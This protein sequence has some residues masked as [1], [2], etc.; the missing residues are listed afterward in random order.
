MSS[1]YRIIPLGGGGGITPTGTLDIRSEGVFDVTD[2]ASVDV[3]I[4]DDT[5]TKSIT[6]NGT[7]NAEDDHV[8]GYSQVTVAV[9]AVLQNKTVTPTTSQQTVE[10]DSGQGYDGLGTVTINGVTSAIDANIIAS[11][12]R[13]G[14]TILGVTGTYTGGAMIDPQDFLHF[15][16]P[17]DYD[18]SISVSLSSK[19]NINLYYSKDYTLPLDTW[20]VF[21][22]STSINLSSGES[23]YIY[24]NNPLGLF[25]TYFNTPSGMC[26]CHGNIMSL[27]SIEDKPVAP[28]NAF[29]QLFSNTSITTP[30]DLPATIVGNS[31][32]SYMFNNCFQLTQ[33][34][35]L[36]A[37]TL[38]DSCYSGMFYGCTSLTQAPVLPATTLAEACYDSMFAGCSSLVQAPVLPA[39]TLAIQCYG[40]M[41]N[42]CLSLV[43]APALPATTLADGCYSGMFYNCYRMTQAP[44]LPATTLAAYCYGQMFENCSALNTPPVLPATTLAGGCYNRMFQLCTSLTQAPALP[45]TTL[46]DGCYEQM[47]SGC[48]SLNEISISFSD[49]QNQKWYDQDN[50]YYPFSYSWTEN[51]S[52][53]GTFK[54]LGNANIPTNDPSSD[55]YSGI[56]ENWTVQTVDY[57]YIQ[58][59]DTQDLTF[60]L[61]TPNYDYSSNDLAWSKDMSTWTQFTKG[62]SQTQTVPL[63]QGEKLYLRSSTGFARYYQSIYS[64]ITLSC[65]G[66]FSA[67]GD[68]RTLINYTD[69]SSVTSLPAGAFYR[70]FY[71]TGNLTEIDCTLN[72]VT[73]IGAISFGSFAARTTSGD[74]NLTRV[75][76]WMPDVTSVNGSTQGHAG[77]MA[78]FYDAFYFRSAL[79]EIT[80]P[81]LQTWDN[82]AFVSWMY[83]V[84]STGTAYVPTGVTIPSNSNGIP[85]NWTRVNY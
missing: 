3:D 43:Q 72:G 68:M 39:T 26:E 61:N 49:T 80:V 48:T 6:A 37:T 28:A 74:T 82:T 22:N 45:A 44:A 21:D 19:F 40:S 7:Y 1:K 11:N 18:A 63:L 58:N 66:L 47:F 25:Y 41:F 51:V 84:N 4:F 16:N 36:P 62:V 20:A 78:S 55:M 34:P 70:M 8:L 35:V 64:P 53:S 12:I 57:F 46:A 50:D 73:T 5:T 77:T 54:K 29:Y 60:T 56:P 10:K 13:D 33:A 15:Y 85:A 38:A 27:L 32:Y 14:V 75:R 59:E 9:E 71:D 65:N 83:G 2:Y 76:I 52:Q 17:K 23:V 69:V 30:P 79:Q 42:N 24:G 81:N 67:H 31:A